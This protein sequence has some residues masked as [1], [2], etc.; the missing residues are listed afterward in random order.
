[1]GLAVLMVMGAAL[2]AVGSDLPVIVVGCVLV[3][4]GGG[5]FTLLAAAIA[6]EF[7]AEGVGRAFGLCMF[8]IPVVTLA[9]YAIA[10]T[11]ESTGSYAPAF[12]GM[13]ILAAISGVLAMLLRERRGAPPARVEPQPDVSANP[14]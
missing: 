11:Q 12:I 13:A 10:K 1:I 9:P 2:L 5:V 6:T 7:G 14:L 4:M 8:F 3:G